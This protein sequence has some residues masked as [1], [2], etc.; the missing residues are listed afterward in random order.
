MRHHDPLDAVG[1]REELR[2][3]PQHLLLIDAAAF[4]RQ[5]AGRVD[6]GN[7]KLGIHEPGLQ[8]V[9]NVLPVDLKPASKPGVDVVERDVVIA[10][11]NDLRRRERPQEG[12]GSFEL[13]RPGALREVARYDNDVGPGLMNRVNQL[14]DDSVIGPAEVEVGEMDY[15]SDA[16]SFLRT[17]TRRAARRVR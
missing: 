16:T 6:A 5:S 12:T 8:V 10:R 17:M 14:L 11:H 4:E 15:G 9:A 2:F 1:Q 13:T 3:Q 7:R